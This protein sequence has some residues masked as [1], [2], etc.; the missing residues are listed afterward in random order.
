MTKIRAVLL[1]GVACLFSSNTWALTGSEIYKGCYAAAQ[2]NIDYDSLP[3]GEEVYVGHCV[4]LTTGFVEMIRLYEG[5]EAPPV[6][7]IPKDV[8]VP[9]LLDDVVDFLDQNRAHWERSASVLV[10]IAIKNNY[11]CDS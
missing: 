2:D 5:T 9:M 3:P 6:A 7:C 8:T 4:G 10:M 1:F 11:L